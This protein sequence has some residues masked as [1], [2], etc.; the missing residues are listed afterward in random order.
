[1][2]RLKSR[3]R[4]KP[5]LKVGIYPS[6]AIQLQQTTCRHLHRSRPENVLN[7]SSEYAPPP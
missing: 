2:G 6:Y 1:M 7:Y 4:I 3:S 5:S